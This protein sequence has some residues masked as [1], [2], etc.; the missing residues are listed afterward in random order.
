MG[1][2]KLTVWVAAVLLLILATALACSH[3]QPATN[4]A[5]P[6]PAPAAA[7]PASPATPASAAT[8][9][10]SAP[11]PVA[12]AEPAK[13]K[14]QP[15]KPKPVS[16]KPSPD[17]SATVS[18]EAVA[19]CL[20]AKGVTMYGHY[21]CPHCAKQKQMFG[22]AFSQVP[23][24]ECGIIGKPMTVQ[25]LSEACREMQITKF[26]TWVFPD[27]DRLMSEQPLDKLAEKAGCKVQ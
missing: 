17:T 2:P 5:P 15:P 11:P 3:S 4:A 23:Y 27:G 24:V 1:R 26:P 22:T 25:Y 9:A 16:A 14:P 6:Q 19:K 12:D 10:A 18:P 21:L 13:A 20:K 8:V 7:A